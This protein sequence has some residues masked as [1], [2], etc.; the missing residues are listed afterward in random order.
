MTDAPAGVAELDSALEA[1][2]IIKR[3][4]SEGRIAFDASEDRRPDQMAG[5]LADLRR[6]LEQAPPGGAD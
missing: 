2:E 6:A 4:T 1:L 3:L 5:L